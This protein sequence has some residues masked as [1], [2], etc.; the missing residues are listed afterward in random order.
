[1]K[2]LQNEH[3]DYFIFGHRHIPFDVHVGT[4]S[5]VVNLGDWINNFTYAVWDG[6]EL[7]LHSIFPEKEK[8]IY[9]R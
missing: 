8:E 1:M 9:R 3:F 5:R 4:N 6:K 7:E 2:H